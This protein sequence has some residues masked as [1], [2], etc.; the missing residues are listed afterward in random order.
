MSLPKL[1]P[2]ATKQ[3]ATG[4]RS[5]LIFFAL[6]KQIR[7]LLGALQTEVRKKNI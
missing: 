3:L 2:V 1:P 4:K 7:F 6:L 5:G